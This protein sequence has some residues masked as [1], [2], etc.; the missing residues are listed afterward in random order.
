MISLLKE[1]EATCDAHRPTPQNH[2]AWDRINR[3]LGLMPP[4]EALD[5]WRTRFQDMK[6]GHGLPEG[7]AFEQTGG[8]K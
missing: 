4:R 1:M 5:Y 3:Y 6:R 7:E 8:N 2:G